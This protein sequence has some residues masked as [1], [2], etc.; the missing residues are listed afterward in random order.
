MKLHLENRFLKSGCNHS[1]FHHSHARITKITLIAAD[2]KHLHGDE[3]IRRHIDM[4]HSDCTQP[5]VNQSLSASLLFIALEMQAYR[6][7][8]DH[9]GRFAPTRGAT[10]MFLLGWSS[11]CAFNG[12][13]ALANNTLCYGQQS[14]NMQARRHN[15]RSSK[16]TTLE[17][18][19]RVHFAPDFTVQHIPL[20]Q[21]L[22]NRITEREPRS[23][24]PPQPCC[25]CFGVLFQRAVGSGCELGSPGY[26]EC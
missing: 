23:L 15:N 7:R 21:N 24:A 5:D 14:Y 16:T 6:S 11:V 17:L 10:S 2:S 18:C 4:S 12:V 1:N 3:A 9:G 25:C 19:G 13:F 26:N 22:I 20:A 8:S